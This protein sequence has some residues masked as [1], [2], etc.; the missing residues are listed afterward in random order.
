MKLIKPLIFTL[1]LSSVAV[2]PAA[3]DTAVENSVP[4]SDSIENSDTDTTPAR[5]MPDP[6][7]QRQ[8]DLAKAQDSETEV[9]WLELNDQKQLALLQ[10][11]ASPSP[12]GSIL[13]FPDRDTGADWPSIVRPL[14]TQMT[15]YDWNTLSLTLPEQPAKAIPGRTLPVL[16]E[17]S[18]I[19]TTT[20]GAE[21]LPESPA[22]DTLSTPVTTPTNTSEETNVSDYN[23]LIS[24]LG[25]L[26]SD[27]LT[28]L[29]GNLT[30]I[31]GIGEG[32][33]WAM[34]YFSQDESRENRF[35]VLLDPI[36]PLDRSAPKLIE[37]ISET[38]APVL[39]LWFNSN[40]F[41]QQQAA[42]R[43]RTIRRSGNNGYQQI[44]LNQRSNDPRREP[45]WLT[46]QLRGI[47]KTRI[48]DKQAEKSPAM[49]KVEPIDLAPGN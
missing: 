34:H 8:T 48:I 36:Q 35:L 40:Q 1:F 19:Q 7:Q 20:E 2:L 27:Q 21:E 44:R 33:T 17:R 22:E 42:L 28:N 25:Q 14:R 10:K 6:A 13:I 26:A 31:L 37:M 30:I 45:L 5:A 9:I 18:Q 4:A 49:P 32:A 29:D 41:K 47:L 3:E 43:K 38:K 39:D 11:A 12:I 46:R 24:E 23:K 15:E 16:Q